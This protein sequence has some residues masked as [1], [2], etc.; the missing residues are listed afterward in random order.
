MY[1]A[2]IWGGDHRRG[3]ER[4]CSVQGRFCKNVLRIPRFVTNGFADLELGRDSR[5]G[6]VLCLTMKY[7]LRI[8]RM[9]K[10]ELVKGCYE[11]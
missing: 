11:W 5:R 1:G 6:K 2:E 4:D 10:E 9:E 7:W 3:G 8:L